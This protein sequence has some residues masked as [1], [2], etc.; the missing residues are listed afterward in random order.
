MAK[1]AEELMVIKVSQIVKDSQ[2]A[3]AK[4]T[5]EFVSNLEEVISELLGKDCV[6]EVLRED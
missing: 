5:P 3:E 4:I 6:I 2:D 1:I